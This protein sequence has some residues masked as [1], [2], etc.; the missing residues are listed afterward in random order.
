MRAAITAVAIGLAAVT[1]RPRGAADHRRGRH[2]PGPGL[3]EMGRGGEGR[4]RHRAELPGDRL[5]RRAEPDPA[6]GRSISAPPTRR[7]TRPS[8]PSGNL[9]QFPTVMGA[10]VVDREHPRHQAERAEA[11]RRG[12]GRH[13]RRQD[14][15]VERPQAGR[16]ERGPEAAE[17]G[18]RAGATAPTA[19]APP[20]SS[21]PIS[22]AV[23][24]EWK[25][26]VGANTSVNWPA[27]AGAKG[28]DGVAATMQQHA[29]R[30]RLCR[31]RLCH[32]EQAGHHAAAQQGRPVRRADAWR[33][34]PPAAANGDWANA[35]NYRRQPD[36]P[37]GRQQLADRLGHLHLLPKNPKDAARSRN[38]MKFFDWAYKNGDEH[39]A[40]A[41]IHPAA[42]GGA[43]RGPRRLAGRGQ[44][45]GRQAGLCSTLDC[46]GC[47]A[48]QVRSRHC[49]VRPTIGPRI[50]LQ[51]AVATCQRPDDAQ[52][53][54]RR[55]VFAAVARR[56]RAWCWC[57]SAPSSSCCSSAA[58]RPSAPSAPASSGRADWDPVQ[59]VFGAAVPIYGTVVTSVL[60]LH[61][62]RAARVRHRL[63][64]DRTGARLAAPPGRHRGR[65]A[66]GRAVDHLRH[67][68]L[69]R[70]RAGHGAVRPAVADRQHR[71]AAGASGSCSR[72]RPSAPAS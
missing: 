21:P 24:P 60:A 16:A 49:P 30:H 46:R 1:C 7:W 67:V 66:G 32:A 42:G 68:G 33:P 23:S 40:A 37:A 12:A 13:L 14:H 4:G 52:L 69:L 63:L 3:H 10:V 11:D 36:R 27:G 59:E 6:T 39:R 5:G 47:R 44:G 57:C 62:G 71:R 17:P 20:T 19:P 28:N 58:C 70:H 72:A 8:W 50:A 15:E 55:R 54:P 51:Q 61:P 26:K 25:S 31:E 64:P 35:Q 53:Q 18:D 43:G 34:S 56:R 48:R 41:G 9:L 2:L 38:V 22:S 65:A 45:A 29:R